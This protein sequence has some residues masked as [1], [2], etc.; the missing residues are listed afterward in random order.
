MQANFISMLKFISTSLYGA[1]ILFLFLPFIQV[2]CNETILAESSGYQA[3]T[4][5]KPKFVDSSMESYLSGQEGM[6]DNL[7]KQNKANVIL[8]VFGLMLLAGLIFSILAKR[9][10][11]LGNT[12][13]SS[14]A[15]V[16]LLVF[17]A[18]IIYGNHEIKKQSAMMQTGF[19]KIDLGLKMAY[20]YWLSLITNIILLVLSILW[21]VQEKRNKKLMLQY[22]HTP[23]HEAPDETTEV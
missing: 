16:C 12:V 14:I 4:G 19:M 11:H 17:L 1:L 8:I 23:E 20:G 9:D 5:G 10:V 18:Q 21:L 6:V 22:E 13:F 3:M 15:I 2:K 7:Q